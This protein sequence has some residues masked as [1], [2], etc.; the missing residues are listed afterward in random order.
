MNEDMKLWKEEVIEIV[1]NYWSLDSRPDLLRDIVD[2]IVRIYPEN[3]DDE[4]V[5]LGEAFEYLQTLSGDAISNEDLI[6]MAK[7]KKNE[8]NFS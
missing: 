7:E 3:N 6:H 4:L 5:I 2:H 1:K 8:S